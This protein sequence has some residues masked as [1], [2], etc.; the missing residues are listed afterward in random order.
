ME[1]L[2][3]KEQMNLYDDLIAPAISVGETGEGCH[4]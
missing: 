1:G 3:M 4:A 2:E